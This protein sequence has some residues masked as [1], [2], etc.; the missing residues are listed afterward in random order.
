MRGAPRHSQ[1][2]TNAERVASA[3]IMNRGLTAWASNLALRGGPPVQQIETGQR[4]THRHAMS[5]YDEYRE[6]ASTTWTSPWIVTQKLGGDTEDPSYMAA[7]VSTT[8]RRDGQVRAMLSAGMISE[9]TAMGLKPGV[10]ASIAH[11]H[12]A[13]DKKGLWVANAEVLDSD[14][15]RLNEDEV[16]RFTYRRPWNIGQRLTA[17]ET[18]IDRL[19]IA[20]AEIST[21]LRENPLNAALQ[22]VVSATAR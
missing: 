14:I 10:S 18:H 6:V 20:R 5:P 17:A 11:A 2:P 22:D 3:I 8:Q 21:A 15:E 16:F 4:A 7:L 9:A 1:K 12:W 19:E 13:N